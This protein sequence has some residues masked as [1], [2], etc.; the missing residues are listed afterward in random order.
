MLRVETPW[1]VRPAVAPE[2]SHADGSGRRGGGDGGMIYQ[3]A[4]LRGIAREVSQRL[5]ASDA[6]AERADVLELIGASAGES[7]RTAGC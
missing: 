2:G 4:L 5:R 3:P 6:V 7:V 1:Q